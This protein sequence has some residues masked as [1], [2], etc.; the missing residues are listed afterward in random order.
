MVWLA[1]PYTMLLAGT[2]GI[3]SGLA[4]QDRRLF[5]LA[6]DGALFLVSD[7]MLAFGMFWGHFAHQTESVWLTYGPGQMLIVF[8]VLSAAVVLSQA[9]ARR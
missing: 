1:L 4:L 5:G 6:L 9:V 7:L 3:S 8:S 2:A